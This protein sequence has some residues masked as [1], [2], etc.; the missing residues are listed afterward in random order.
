MDTIRNVGVL[1]GCLFDFGF[2][3]KSAI[4]CA[5]KPD[6]GRGRGKRGPRILYVYTHIYIYIYVPGEPGP[7][8]PP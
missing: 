3:E 4:K 8:A 6:S 5:T 1:T 7:G 2:G